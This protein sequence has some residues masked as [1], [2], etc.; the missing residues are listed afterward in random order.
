MKDQSHLSQIH[1]RHVQQ[2]VLDSV[3]TLI[4]FF[5][6]ILVPG[7]WISKQWSH[8]PSWLLERGFPAAYYTSLLKYIINIGV[9]TNV[10][11][12]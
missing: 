8:D 9:A 4:F 5:P 6:F 11:L 3:L 10:Q 7:E 2:R 1:E 12:Y